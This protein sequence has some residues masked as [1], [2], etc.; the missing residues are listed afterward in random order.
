MNDLL[1]IKFKPIK[2]GEKII[3]E[4]SLLEKAILTLEILKRREENELRGKMNNHLGYHFIVPTQKERD[5]VELLHEERIFL[6]KFVWQLINLRLK[7][8]PE[9]HAIRDGNK[10]VLLSLEEILQHS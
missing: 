5:K 10:I 2:S 3:S 6:D 8:D 7:I 4:L 9:K 1:K